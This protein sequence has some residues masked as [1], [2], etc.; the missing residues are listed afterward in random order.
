[1]YFSSLCTFN[2]VLKHGF[3]NHASLRLTICNTIEREKD[4]R[5]GHER[6]A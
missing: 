2:V 1:M 4:T 3:G 5:K 6:R